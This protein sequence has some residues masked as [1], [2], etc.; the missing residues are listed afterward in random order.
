MFEPKPIPNGLQWR[1]VDSEKEWFVNQ[2]GLTFVE[3]VEKSFN[4][5]FENVPAIVLGEKIKTGCKSRLSWF[6][7]VIPDMEMYALKASVRT[8]Y[9]IQKGFP[10]HWKIKSKHRSETGVER[11]GQGQDISRSL[12]G[13]AISS[14]VSDVTLIPQPREGAPSMKAF[15]GYVSPDI[16]FLDYSTKSIQEKEDQIA[17]TLWGITKEKNTDGNE[18]ATGRYIDQQPIHNALNSLTNVAEYVQNTLANF[19]L[20]AI[21]RTKSKENRYIYIAGRRFLI[22]SVDAVLERYD[23]SRSDNLPSTILDKLLEEWVLTK[24]KTDPLMQDQM[25]KKIKLEPYVHWD[26]VTVSSL[27]SPNEAYK[28]VLFNDWWKK[29]A[30]KSKDF[31][32]LQEDFNLKI[33]SDDSSSRFVPTQGQN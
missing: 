13:D 11:T 3:D 14:D 28:K 2:I 5:P 23:K 7:K 1:V 24:Y 26:I 22:E 18:T 15:S 4:H 12:Q 10:E 21:D 27:F 9:E 6:H 19:V 20:K 25:M 29:E 16:D 17:E 32:S 30:D 8:I 31:E 33:K